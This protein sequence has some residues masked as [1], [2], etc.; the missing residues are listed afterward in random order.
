MPAPTS[1]LPFSPDN[2]VHGSEISI[3]VALANG[4][5]LTIGELYDLTWTED[6]MMID[7]MPFGSR[8]IGQRQGR[9]KVTGNCSSYYINGA[10]RG[11]VQGQSNPSASGV[12]S[13]VYHSQ[14]AFY[15]YQIKL[16]SS[17]PNVQNVVFVNCTFGKDVLKVA[18]DKI[19]EEVLDWQAE[20]VYAY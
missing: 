18:S 2:T 11:I 10:A 20:D 5:Y 14:A 17:N 16:L 6:D 7:V 13:A 1:L 8:L 15:R 9:F 19:L 3:Q 12:A 4:T